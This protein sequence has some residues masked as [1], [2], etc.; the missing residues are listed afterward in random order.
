MLTSPVPAAH[1]RSVIDISKRK[2]YASKVSQDKLHC[3]GPHH[4][5]RVA[6]ELACKGQLSVSQEIFVTP[7]SKFL[8]TF[9]MLMQEQDSL[10]GTFTAVRQPARRSGWLVLCSTCSPPCVLMPNCGLVQ[11]AAGIKS[12]FSR[13]SSPCSFTW[14]ISFRQAAA[15]PAR[16]ALLH[17]ISLKAFSGV[18]TSSQAQPG[19]HTANKYPA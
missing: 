1:D 18:P 6:R 11:Q 9:C 2:L 16:M 12:K 3:S 17:G 7:V 19:R 14:Q 5:C 15:L 13:S 10:V 8:H 4:I